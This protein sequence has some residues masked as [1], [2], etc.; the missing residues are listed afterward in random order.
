MEVLL[1]L[2]STS[3]NA[4]SEKDDKEDDSKEEP[5]RADDD[6]FVHSAFYTFIFYNVDDVEDADGGS[7]VPGDGGKISSSRHY[8]ARFG[9]FFV[10]K[11]FFI[12]KKWIDLHNLRRLRVDI[13]LVSNISAPSNISRKQKTRDIDV[14]YSS[15][16]NGFTSNIG[17]DE[18]CSS[19]A[20]SKVNRLVINEILCRSNSNGCILPTSRCIFWNMNIKAY[21]LIRVSRHHALFGGKINPINNLVIITILSK[22]EIVIITDRE[23][24][25]INRIIEVVRVIGRIDDRKAPGVGFS[26]NKCYYLIH[27]R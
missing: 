21:F 1:L 17:V 20:F 16:P 15:F 2:F 9:F 25:D 26:G 5:K 7:I 12:G 4:D 19:V 6:V 14:L 11:D 18:V 13:A 27:G 22:S 23:W 3:N 24:F 10:S 8:P